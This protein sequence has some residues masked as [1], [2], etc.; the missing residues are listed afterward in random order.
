MSVRPSRSQIACRL[1]GSSHEENPF[2]SAV[3]PIPAA[4]LACRLA[5][6]CSLSHSLIG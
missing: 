3:Q 1:A 6:S 5:H 2:A 4:R